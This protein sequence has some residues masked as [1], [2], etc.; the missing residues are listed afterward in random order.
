[1]AESAID[2]RSGVVHFFVI[3][4]LFSSTFL[5]QCSVF[6]PKFSQCAHFFL[7][8]AISK[9]FLVHWLPSF[10]CS[11]TSIYLRARSLINHLIAI[12]FYTRG[13]GVS[14]RFAFRWSSLLCHHWLFLFDYL[15]SVL[16]ITKHNLD[17]NVHI[18]FEI[19]YDFLCKYKSPHF[20]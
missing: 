19:A 6:I 12:F 7:L 11:V 2:S 18:C 8:N 20:T 4:D 15:E 14:D 16:F 10:D 9:Y 17:V 13:D 1:M 3:I 5:S